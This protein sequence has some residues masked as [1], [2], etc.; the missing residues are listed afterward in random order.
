MSIFVRTECVT[1]TDKHGGRPRTVE[2]DDDQVAMRLLADGVPLELLVDIALPT[3]LLPG[4]GLNAERA[5]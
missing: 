5:G 2:A 4:V 1:M 3:G